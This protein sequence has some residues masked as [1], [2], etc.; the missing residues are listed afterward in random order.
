MKTTAN[1]YWY[2]S[3]KSIENSINEVQEDFQFSR[4]ARRIIIPKQNGIHDSD[5]CDHAHSPGSSS[6]PQKH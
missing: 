4:S 3:G 6:R 2:N 1:G 5:I